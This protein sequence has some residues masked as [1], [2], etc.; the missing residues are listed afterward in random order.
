[1]ALRLTPTNP[2]VRALVAGTT[3]SLALGVAHAQMEMRPVTPAAFEQ[4]SPN[5]LYL[6]AGIVDT[7]ASTPRVSL[8]QMLATAA[9]TDRF[10]L[11]LDGPM[12][13]ERR[14]AMQ[15]SGLRVHDYL[16]VNA[17][18]VS[19]T[20]PVA[21]AGLLG[22]V[23]WHAP[24]DRAWKIQP[25]LGQRT[26]STPERQLMAQR[27][28]VGVVVVLFEGF[29]DQV[30]ID[31]LVGLGDA[32]VH[33]SEVM[34]SNV[35]VH[36]TMKL[37]DVE[38]LA[39]LSAVQFIE[40]AWEV[41]LRNS[42]NRWV[43][44]TGVLNNMP[45][46][47]N[48][49]RGAG[50]IVGILDGRVDHDHC[51]F[52]DTNPIGTTHRKIKA[53]NTSLGTDDH[54]THVAGTVV[55]DAGS[56]DSN[57]GVAY[58]GK[59]VFN[60]TPAFNESSILQRL[61][62]HGSQGA[63]IHTNSWGDDGTTAYNSLARG[64][65][66]YSR[67]TETA[68]VLLAVT[69]T[70]TLRNPENAKNLLACGATQDTP[71]LGSHCSGGVGP[72]SDGRRKPEIYAPGCGT[73]SS[74]GNTSCGTRSLT[75]TSMATPAIAGAA[76]L[77]RQYFGDGFYPSG[78][79]N[80]SDAISP[81]G[82]LVKAVLLN[83]AVDMTNVSGYPSNLEGW[84]RV[85]AADS[86]YFDGDARNLYIETLTNR[87][88]LSTGE[89][90]SFNV[91]V[92]DPSE[93]LKI[94]MVFTDVAAASGASFAP[95]NDLDLEV[96][97]PTGAVYRGNVFSGG[98]STTGGS[99]DIRNNVEQVHINTPQAGNWTV[100]I[101]ASAVNQ[102]VQG[103]AMVATGGISPQPSGVSL[104]LA[105]PVPSLLEPGV[106]VDID[107]N[108]VPG[109]DSVIGGSETFHYSFDGGAYQTAS[110]TPLGGDLFR[111]TL[112]GAACDDM[113]RFYFSA[114]GTTSGVITLPAGA[115][116]NRFEA[117]V[118]EEAITFE[119]DMETNQGWI[120]GAAGDTATTGIWTR[121]N[122]VGTSAQP[123]DDNTGAG[124]QCWV[125]GQGTVG[126]GLGDNDVDGGQ[127]TLTSPTI[128]LAAAQSATISYYRWYSNTEGAS[129]AAD[130]FEID[131][132]DN[133]GASWTNVETVG[134]ATENSGGWIQHSFNV[135]DFVGLT[136]QVVMRFIAADEGSGSIVEAGIDDFSVAVFECEDVVTPSCPGDA[137]GSGTVD[138]DDLNLILGNWGTAGPD[139]DVAPAPDGNGTV[140][141]DDLNLVLG[142][143]NATCN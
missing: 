78:S 106:S 127:T 27:G 134:P 2:A 58:E 82:A 131:I 51:A 18:I 79:A 109:A 21:D 133:G 66:V 91:S 102:D 112:P 107:V 130:V 62:Q 40:E 35:L 53:Y 4:I 41:E 90:N 111:A 69:N 25:G 28:E 77:V 123:E 132:S 117:T 126:G 43:V 56:N 84:G 13:P 96:V 49:I 121:V 65:D 105:S 139:G 110:L 81:S 30:V 119:D 8:Q 67:D 73:I 63:S 59:F 55:G 95:V 83:S 52:N 20:E 57:R 80:L 103:Y 128:D 87:F 98:Q 88:G 122:P 22:F 137:N 37:E 12:T 36:A 143:W 125:T 86:L 68:L 7:A 50:E 32:Q 100:N 33:Y 92:Q 60:T 72:T 71:N 16:P 17:Y 101:I 75:G 19:V 135:E 74:D 120:A 113:P 61:E 47:D 26:Y 76:M 104:S 99:F 48:G 64:F 70:S 34:G 31:Q 114:E 136:N 118:G 138:F 14:D 38:Q 85:T 54:G 140:D 23:Q 115:P 93:P 141:F 11:Q 3:M 116:G 42:T 46:Y 1:M 108:I 15:R 94:T 45:I 97:S 39:D 6:Q 5:K 10:V 9:P 124:T 24:F 129:P 44:Q 29:G 142:N 89:S